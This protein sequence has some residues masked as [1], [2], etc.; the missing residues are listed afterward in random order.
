MNGEQSTRNA[1]LSSVHQTA[2]KV[3]GGPLAAIP[4]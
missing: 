2:V 3:N 1:F 4:E